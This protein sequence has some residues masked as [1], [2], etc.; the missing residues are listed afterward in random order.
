MDSRWKQAPR[1]GT[2][3]NARPT[4]WLEENCSPSTT[5]THPTNSSSK[6]AGHSGPIIVIIS[7][8][9]FW[10]RRANRTLRLELISRRSRRKEKKP[11]WVQKLFH[12]NQFF[13]R[14]FSN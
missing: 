5:A 4:L 1:L 11:D 13:S 14:A 12:H 9:T 8:L 6:Q 3:G 7:Q 10:R 2:G